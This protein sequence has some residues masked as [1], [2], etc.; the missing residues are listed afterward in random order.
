ERL[1]LALILASL[2]GTLH[3]VMAI[4]RRVRSVAVASRPEKISTPVASTDAKTTTIAG[5][6]PTPPAKKPQ[7][8]PMP[9]ARPAEDP[10]APILARIDGAI[11]REA[12]AAGAADRRAAALEEARG[13]SVAESQRWKR[14]EMLVRQQVAT[15][16]ERADRLERDALTLNAERDVLAR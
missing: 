13:T 8:A 9:P 10:T 6:S 5:P 16:S 4:H 3:L 2:G 12:E 15:L 14:R 11:A 1:V 7:A